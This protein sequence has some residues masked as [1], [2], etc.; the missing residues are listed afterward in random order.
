MNTSPTNRLANFANRVWIFPSAST[1]LM[2]NVEADVSV[3]WNVPERSGFIPHS[4]RGKRYVTSESCGNKFDISLGTAIATYE[5][6]SPTYRFMPRPRVIP[7][8]IHTKTPSVVRP[9]EPHAHLMS[10][11]F[12]TGV[13]WLLAL[14]LVATVF[15]LFFLKEAAYLAAIPIPILY[16]L[17]VISNF[18]EKRSRASNFRSPDE[19]GISAKEIEIDVETVGIVTLIEV[20]VCLAIGVFIIA[21]SFY[22]WQLVGIVT[23]TLFLL[24]VT[25]QLPFLPLY[26]S[27]AGRDERDKLRER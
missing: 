4:R 15:C 19:T 23:A 1:P 18:L 13:R 14:F 2:A 7:M 26:F 22:A 11:H 20:V 24:I 8:S 12:R 25:I 16:A 6:T 17:L 5:P 21:A 9:I 10:R 27:E 3:D